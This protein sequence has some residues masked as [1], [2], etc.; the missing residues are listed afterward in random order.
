MI[1]R[2]LAY[3]C[4]LAHACTHFSLC[5]L[6]TA[7]CKYP[8]MHVCSH[9]C[10]CVCTCDCGAELAVVL[11]DRDAERNMLMLAQQEAESSIA[12]PSHM[13]HILDSDSGSESKVMANVDWPKRLCCPDQAPQLLERVRS[14]YQ[15]MHWTSNFLPATQLCASVRR[16]LI[17]KGERVLPA[18]GKRLLAICNL[19][20]AENDVGA[21]VSDETDASDSDSN[22][23]S[24]YEHHALEKKEVREASELREG[25]EGANDGGEGG[26]GGEVTDDELS[27]DDKPLVRK[28]TKKA[29][30]VQLPGGQLSA[31]SK[32]KLPA[33]ESSSRKKVKVAGFG[34]VQKVQAEGGEGAEGGDRGKTVHFAEGQGLEDVREFEVPSKCKGDVGAH[35]YI[36]PY[37]Y[38]AIT[39]QVISI[40][41]HPCMG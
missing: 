24:D 6:C 16:S 13:E 34:E 27:D 17:P 23:D 36:G 35:T 11:H 33:P 31:G 28:S 41:I 19:V 2:T 21:M 14:K 5:L 30:I 7:S 38:R 4:V 12:S 37:I 25:V 15:A 22:S 18:F 26:E 9:A 8:H 10:T 20:V 29:E 39:I 3:A 40:W 32:H 1:L